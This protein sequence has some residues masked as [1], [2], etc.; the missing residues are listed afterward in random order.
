MKLSI[1]EVAG[2]VIRDIPHARRDFFEALNGATSSPAQPLSLIGAE[3]VLA[4]VP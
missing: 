2:G 4:Y 3:Q 1:A